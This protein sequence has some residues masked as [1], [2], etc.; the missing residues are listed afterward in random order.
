MAV[1]RCSLLSVQS[2]LFGPIS[3]LT[4]AG[5]SEGEHRLLLM[6]LLERVLDTSSL[7]NHLTA[8]GDCDAP[9]DV[10]NDLKSIALTLKGS[11]LGPTARHA[12][13]TSFRSPST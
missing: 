5:G 11:T 7:V 4:S 8:A 2:S 13:H 3:R 9:V 6:L 10:G 1:A 12:I